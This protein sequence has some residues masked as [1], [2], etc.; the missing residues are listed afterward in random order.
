MA[1]SKKSF[2]NA[3]RA[4]G[5]VRY[6][7]LGGQATPSQ[8]APVPT[9][10]SPTG[11]PGVNNGEGL[12]GV[13][14]SVLTPQNGFQAQLAPTQNLDYSG[15]INQAGSQALAGNGLQANNIAQEQSLQQQLINQGNGQ[16]PNP[17]Q[18]ALNQATGN[19]IASQAALMANQ[20]GGSANAG[21]IARQAAQQGANTQQQAVG[22]G[23]TLQAQQQL[24]AQ[25]GAAALQ[26]QIGNQIT[27]QQSANNQLLGIGAGA[28]NTQNANLVSNYGQAQGINAQAA[29]N[30]AN[31]NGQTF[32]GL[33]NS[34][35]DLLSSLFADGGKVGSPESYKHLDV[36]HYADGGSVSWAGQFLNSSPDQQASFATPSSGAVAQPASATLA[37]P[38][39]PKSS[40]DSGGGGGVMSLLA[41]LS[42]G[43]ETKP[44]V[45]SMVSPGEKILPPDK[46]N[47]P[48]PLKDAK[49]VPG[50]ASVKGNSLKND[51]VPAD[52]PV[53]AIVLPRSVTQAK[54]APSRAAAFVQA[55][56]AK[57]G[58][59]RKAKS[60]G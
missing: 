3:V 38:A 57:Q 26:G 15:L 36:M 24:A 6:F 47:S 43:G 59:K 8:P 42:K 33:L 51:T 54:D 11:A 14:G 22:Q 10:A 41:L 37:P 49:E 17:A 4:R 18:A 44:A 58:L 16:G 29:Q 27:N 45:K 19:N 1:K 21:L 20:R 53:G 46:V 30:N 35:S 52:L 31:A 5:G 48:N 25:Q 12:T 34:G 55:I 40:S 32:S 23:A 60:N 13:I 28:T 39:P 56:Q 9:A 7:D 50:K 2:V